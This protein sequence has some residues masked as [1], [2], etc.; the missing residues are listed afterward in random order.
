MLRVSDMAAASL[1]I[2][3]I[4]RLPENYDLG[5]G[6]GPLDLL[7]CELN[8]DGPAL[9][10]ASGQKAGLVFATLPPEARGPDRGLSSRWLLA[11]WDRW[12]RFTHLD[13]PVPFEDALVLRWDARSL[14]EPS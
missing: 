12:F 4:L 6:S 5:P 11:N 8:E 9:V 10:V 1:G 14:P 2:G 7:V 3:D 13:A